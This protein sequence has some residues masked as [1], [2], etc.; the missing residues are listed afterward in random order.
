MPRLALA[1]L[2]ALGVQTTGSALAGAWLFFLLAACVITYPQYQPPRCHNAVWWATA[3]WLLVLGVAT[4]LRLWTEVFDAFDERGF[5][6]LITGVTDH[7]P[8]IRHPPPQG[9]KRIERELET[10][11][12]RG[13]EHEL[14]GVDGR[15]IR[16]ESIVYRVL[17]RDS[18][19]LFANPHA[20]EDGFHP[21]PLRVRHTD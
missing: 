11:V 12:G 18:P 9:A 13:E 10:L 3:L 8:Q 14:A 7:E 4:F 21:A 17:D 15:A 20:A 6:D 1:L 5:A 16:N 19:D 2:V